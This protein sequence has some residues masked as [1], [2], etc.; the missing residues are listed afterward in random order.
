LLCVLLIHGQVL[1]RGCRSVEI[2][3]WDG[4][5]ETPN[6]S[7]GEVSSDSS[8]SDSEAEDGKSLGSKFKK[9][10]SSRKDGQE[11]PAKGPKVSVASKLETKLGSVLRRKSAKSPEQRIEEETAISHMPIQAEPRVLHGH[12]LTKGATFRE[13]CFAIRDS[14]FVAS[15]L[16][17]V[18]SLEVHASLAQ[19]QMMVDIMQDAWK[20][21]LIETQPA[22]GKLPSLADLKGK[23]LIKT[24]GLPLSGD[25]EKTGLEEALKPQSSEN[26]SSGE[27]SP[28]PSKVLGALADLAVYTRAYHFS[29]FDQPGLYHHI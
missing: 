2:D 14:A 16:P 26:K 23:I 1:L 27:Q 15:D 7:D 4:E 22:E 25:A 28:K 6:S 12:T 29:H 13:I 11:K 17:L 5:L 21:M 10:I 24:K 8:S 20:G 3:V 19:Q 18:I 9:K